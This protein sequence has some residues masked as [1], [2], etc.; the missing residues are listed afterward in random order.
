MDTDAQNAA[1]PTMMVSGL[2]MR[3]ELEEGSL[4]GGVEHGRRHWHVVK[5]VF[6]GGPVARANAQ[7]LQD[8]T[9]LVAEGDVL[10]GV[11]DQQLAGLSEVVIRELLYGASLRSAWWRFESSSLEIKLEFAHRSVRASGPQ[12]EQ[13]RFS[14]VVQ[15]QAEGSANRWGARCLMTPGRTFARAL[16]KDMVWFALTLPIVMQ[17]STVLL[18]L[19]NFHASPV[20]S[21]IETPAGMNSQTMACIAKWAWAALPYGIPMIFGGMV[22]GALSSI[23]CRDRCGNSDKFSNALRVFLGLFGAVL[24]IT[25][26]C[27]LLFW[28]FGGSVLGIYFTLGSADV[29]VD[30]ALIKMFGVTGAAI[31]T[32]IAA[33]VQ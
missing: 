17:Q 4:A 19:T 25:G 2:G 3:L 30:L 9:E 13:S 29:L 6:A 5:E 23:E 20:C 21:R 8:G 31:T 33:L 27:M 15:V 14:I 22:C 7:A 10:L 11:G 1:A 16:F 18:A 12:L 28:I 24:V 32:T 26:V